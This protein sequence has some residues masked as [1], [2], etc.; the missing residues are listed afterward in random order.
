MAPKYTRPEAPVPADWPTGSAYEQ[1]QTDA[2]IAHRLT[3]QQ[4]FKDPKLQKT[5]EISLQNNRDLRIAALNV[6]RARGLYGIQRAELLPTLDITG[7]ANKERLSGNFIGTNQSITV[8][9]YSVNL[10][11]VAWEIDFFGRIRNLKDRALKEYLATEHAHRS[12]QILLVS[13]VAVAYLTLA[14]DQENLQ[15]AQSTLGS[16]QDA[17]DL[18]RR[19]YESGLATELDLRQVQTRVDAARVD[20]IIYTRIVAQDE[21]AL[22]LLV[23]SSV[24]AD[25]LPGSMNSISQTEKISPGISS[26]VLLRRPDILQAENL[27]MAA[28]ANIGAARAAFFPRISLTSTVGTASGELSGLFSSGSEVWTFAPRVVIPIFDARIWSG[29]SVTKTDREIALAQYEK[30]IQIAFKEVADALAVQGTIEQQLSAQQSLVNAAAETY[31]L[32]NTR[33]TKGIDSY[34]AVIDAQRSLY[35]AQQGFV[36]FRLAKFANQVRLYAVL[37][38]GG[39]FPKKAKL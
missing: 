27:L 7:S 35:N 38:G 32:S 4:F 8:E 9:N 14:A 28:H 13:E 11:I 19:R 21:T 36:A 10:G 1:T 12:A 33:Y 34:L 30:S 24:P 5:I 16:Q 37:G 18:I 29:L 6:E 39:D 26:E 23:G 17:Y 31:R 22:N 15:L 20:S 25:L 2:P 3:W